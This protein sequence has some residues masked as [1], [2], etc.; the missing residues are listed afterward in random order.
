M[1]EIKPEYKIKIL[2]ETK[3][4]EELIKENKI[5]YKH[6][7]VFCDREFYNNSSNGTICGCCEVH[8]LCS[9]CGNYV[10]VT[11][12]KRYKDRDYL[13]KPCSDKIN[14]K[15]IN[16]PEVHARSWEKNKEKFSKILEDGRKKAHTPEANRRRYEVQKK[17]GSFDKFVKAGVEASLTPEARR[18]QIE[19]KKRNGYYQSETFKNA[20][21]STQ[22]PEAIAK[23]EKSRRES[24][25][26]DRWIEKVAR[27]SS[28]GFNR[29]K[30]YQ[31][32]IDI[33]NYS[34][35]EEMISDFNREIGIPGV[36]CIKDQNGDV[37]DVYETSDIGNEMYQAVRRLSNCKGKTDEE[38][39][40][41]RYSWKKV[42]NMTECG[43]LNFVIVVRNMEDKVERMKIEAQYAHD[44]KAKYWNPA[45]GQMNTIGEI[46]SEND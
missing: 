18:K 40:D 37:L 38:L 34:A 44:N 14:V 33:T 32:K 26:L 16:T 30:F 15:K 10:R 23:R 24:G 13:C 36:W 11:D 12:I 1:I 46:G 41:K 17:N 42:R 20:I 27:N 19:T 45:P 9:S 39:S 7:C 25:A 31:D 35:V 21:K 8:L 2:K 6:K 4:K 3:T 29:E 5:A 22:T 28:G 43:K